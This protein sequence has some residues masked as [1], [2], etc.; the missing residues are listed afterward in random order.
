MLGAW[1]S[2][3]MGGGRGYSY[4]VPM[5]IGINCTK[6][7]RVRGLVRTFEQEAAGMGMVGKLPYLVILS[8]WGE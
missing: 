1:G 4:P 6:V 2:D 3:I 8:G 7:A 5:A